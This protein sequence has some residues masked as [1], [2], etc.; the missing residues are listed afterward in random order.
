[1]TLS[2]VKE[3]RGVGTEY[4]EEHFTRDSA[5]NPLM[6]EATVYE[7]IWREHSLLPPR[8]DFMTPGWS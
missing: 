4:N 5:H 7:R 6:T 1:M 3:T 8:S 2:Y